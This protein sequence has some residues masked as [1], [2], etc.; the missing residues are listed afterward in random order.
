MRGIPADLDLTSLHGAELVQVCLGVWQVQFRFHTGASIS[1]EGDWDLIDAGGETIDCN[2]DMIR[3]R[4]YHLHLLLGQ[5]VR[6]TEIDAPISFT[7]GFTNG[8]RLRITVSDHGY[9]SCSID[10]L[11]IVL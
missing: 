3:E 10:P 2:S 1:V 11:G 6:T 8:Y 4:P 5:A 9:E 7:L